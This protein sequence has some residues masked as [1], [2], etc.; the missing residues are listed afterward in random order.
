MVSEKCY[1]AQSDVVDCDIGGDRALLHLQTNTYFTMNAT[2]SALWLGLSEPKSLNEMVQIVTEKF[3]VTDDQCRADIE[4][5]VGQMVEANV[6]KVVPN[7][8]E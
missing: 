4:S 2:A 8:A 7:E 1:V 6:V 5:L 3:D